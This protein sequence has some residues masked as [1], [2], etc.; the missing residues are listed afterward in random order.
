MCIRD[1]GDVDE[2]GKEEVGM[3]GTTLV[4][5]T[6]ERERED[7]EEVERERMLEQAYLDGS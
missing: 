4:E 7:E 2:E 5:A 1:R 3:E 6:K